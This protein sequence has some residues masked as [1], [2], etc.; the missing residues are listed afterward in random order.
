[1]AAT[2][3]NSEVKI[4]TPLGPDVL[5]FR[6]MSMTEELGR[7]F[8]IDLTFLSEQEDI[9][10]EKILGE[11]VTIELTLTSGAKRYFNGNVTSFSQTKG[12]DHYSSYKATV[13]PWLWF[14]TRTA[15]CRIFQEMSVPDIVKSVFRDLGY[16]DFEDKLTS[17]YRTWDYCVQYRE[18]DFNFVSR[19]LEQEGIYYY[20]THDDGLHSLVLS[21]GDAAHS[22]LPS[23]AVVDYFPPDRRAVG[24][25]DFISQW[26]FTK[27]VQPGKYQLNEFDFEKPKAKL[28]T[29]SEIIQSHKTADYEIYDYPG[30]Y[31]K[32]DDGD[33]Y[34]QARIEEL[35]CQY[36]QTEGQG[37]IREF[38]SGYKFTFKGYTREDQNREYLIT[39]VTHNIHSHAHISGG[40]D[41]EDP[42]SN[43]FSVIESQTPFRAA[44]ITP[45]PI[46]QGSQTA[47]VVGPSGEEI[48]TDEYGRVKVQFHWDRYGESNE[49]SSCW[50][51]VAQIWAGK[52][53]GG[54]HIPRI[55]QEVIVDFMEGDPDRPIITGRVYN[56]D[57]MPP[58]DLPANKT[59]S[60]IKSRS[61]KN[62]TPAN[63][64]EIRMEDKKGS[65]EL[66]IHAEKNHTNITENDRN[67]DV[68]H[69]RSLHVG[70][71][72]SEAVDNDKSITV[73]VNHS[74]AIGNN[75]QL[76][77]GVNHSEQIGSNMTINVGSNL[78]ETVGINYAE[79][80]GVAMELTIGATYVQSVGLSK[81]VTLGTSKSES[82]GTSK[83]VSIGS[84][85]SEEVGANKSISIGENLDETIGDSHSEAVAKDYSLTAKTI[86]MTAEDSITLTTGKA[87]ITMKKDGTIN[88][89]GKDITVKGSGKINAKASKN[90]I[91][92]GKK[93]LQN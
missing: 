67:E 36:E 54:I 3:S 85:Q 23:N 75:K 87:S 56:A 9:N 78:T 21:D 15:D 79:T 4:K 80:V 77:V 53:W 93:I 60:G 86:S 33:E 40:G 63:F 28:E 90:I 24:K 92:K 32:T 35:H 64:N 5:L 83:T 47:I 39:S 16:T 6:N 61:S 58:Y 18:T 7:L 19:L 89:V 14:L 88:I 48:Y 73:G 41:N 45:K 42:Y 65:E 46:V 37:T 82:I 17:S 52:K 72:K 30:E 76:S 70:H 26:N 74:E 91:M 22:S 81:T 8:T 13:K 31:T 51:R 44:R 57:Q 38:T 27:Q 50:V 84:D 71:D 66:Y 69:D 25:K 20:F 59:Q 2:Q 12:L 1:M 62:G 34:V 11:N 29:K 68:G 49:N 43:Y 55:G 10:F